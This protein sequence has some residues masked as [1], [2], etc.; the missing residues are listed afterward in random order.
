MHIHTHTPHMHRIAGLCK[1]Y[2]G[3]LNE[4]A[5][6]LNFVLI[7]ELL[8]EVLVSMLYLIT[9]SSLHHHVLGT[10]PCSMAHHNILN[11]HQLG[12]KG[13]VWGSCGG[14]IVREL[15]GWGLWGLYSVGGIVGG[16]CGRVMGLTCT[17]INLNSPL[18]SSLFNPL[19]VM[20][21]LGYF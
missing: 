12:T 6:R 18:A 19:V 21:L 2:C 14:G 8:D 17:C 9:S 15:W 1:D 5:I 3:L 7:Y 10:L 16:L 13:G 11:V 4:E 20:L